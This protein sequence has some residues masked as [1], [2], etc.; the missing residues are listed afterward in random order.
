MSGFAGALLG[1]LG[2]GAIGSAVVDLTLDS[3][4]Y[5]SQLNAAKT[6][7]TATTSSMAKGFDALKGVGVLAF[8]A[9]GTAAVAF[10]GDS[11]Q[12]AIEAE[13]VQ[14][15]LEAAIG[16]S[17]AA[18]E[19]QATALMQVTG[20]SDEA[21]LSADTLL[22]RFD[23][24]AEEVRAA[25]PIVLD[26]AQAVGKDVPTA[27]G[28]V[29]KALLGNTRALKEVGISYTTTG[30][31]A[32]DFE[33]ILGLLNDKVGGTAEAFGR[34]TAGQM[35]IFGEQIDE[36]K[37]GIGSALIPAL[38]ELVPALT[39]LAAV[40]SPI[41]SAAAAAAVG[42]LVEISEELNTILGILP[43][44]ESETNAT[45][46]ATFGWAD[47]LKAGVLE[48]FNLGDASTVAQD[49]VEA[50]AGGMEDAGKTTNFTAG[51]VEHYTGVLEGLQPGLDE[52]ERKH[53][54]ITD[55]QKELRESFRET[56]TV[57]DDVW[58]TMAEKANLTARKVIEA[59]NKQIRAQQ[60]WGAN[61]QEVVDRGLPGELQTQFKEMGLESAGILELLADVND[62]KFDKMI[63]KWG[64]SIG[65]TDQQ[66][67]A[68]YRT[69]DAL[70]SIPTQKQ[71]RI[72]V[73]MDAVAGTGMLA[74]W[75]Q[76]IRDAIAAELDRVNST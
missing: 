10:I 48:A 61:F 52:T 3:S 65:I 60:D 12:A 16:G 66:T 76:E 7:A 58:T 39:D 22:S 46:E 49:K 37:E 34:T 15:K 64:K 25:I 43:G 47:A 9:V 14:Q 74:G 71:I 18:Y 57:A 13:Q 42:P 21:I 11:I 23:L 35:K 75:N 41:L 24:T 69:R 54:E 56:F 28:S 17:T 32:K 30:N 72:Q 31:Q 6:Q 1:G 67:A 59:F 70:N 53:R 5:N 33:N 73:T 20:V 50:L 63:A 8:A 55:A 26:Y 51:L 38:Q 68:F 4:R 27:A 2:G 44:F 45:S 62:R 40:L 29:G 36:M 19:A